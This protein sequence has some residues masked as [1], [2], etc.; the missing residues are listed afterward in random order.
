M[1][2]RPL[3]SVFAAG[4]LGALIH[5][6]LSGQI[7]PDPLDD[8]VRLSP[9]T[10]D[11]T[12]ETGYHPTNAISATRLNARVFELP[13]SLS[14]AT[15]E[16][17]RD[18]GTTD[19]QETIRFLTNVERS[20]TPLTY[21]QYNLR[22]TPLSNR[23]TFQNGRPH[24]R[25]IADNYNIARIEV[26]KGPA[27]PIVGVSPP[28]GMINYM[29]KKPQLAESFGEATAQYGSFGTRRATIDLNLPFDLAGR[30]SGMRVMA[31]HHRNGTK[32]PFEAH[33]IDG[34]T[35]TAS[36]RLTDTLLFETYVEYLKNERVHPAI[37]A[38]AT[39][40]NPGARPPY[41]S[42][43]WSINLRDINGAIIR[44]S[45]PVFISGQP[46]T[47][48]AFVQG[49]Y[50]LRQLAAAAGPDN[51]QN[52]TMFNFDATLTWQPAK[53]FGVEA[54]FS[55]SRSD[56][57]DWRKQGVNLIRYDG[58]RMVGGQPVWNPDG[59]RYFQ[60]QTFEHFHQHPLWFPYGRLSGFYDLDLGFTRQ[61]LR[62]GGEIF[63]QGKRRLT[64][65]R[66]T[67]PGTLT[68]VGFDVYLD[69]ITAANTSK[70]RWIDAGAV[71]TPFVR[72]LLP[73]ESYRAVYATA[74]GSY[75][76]NRVRTVLGYRRDWA[77]LR[78]FAIFNPPVG[79]SVLD[80]PETEIADDTYV[81]D[82][83]ILSVSVSP[84]RKLALY[85]NQS[86]SFMFTQAGQPILNYSGT[87]QDDPT[88]AIAQGRFNPD[89][90]RGPV[91]P[92]ERG[93]GHEYGLKLSLLDDRLS[94]S[95][96]VYSNE[97]V[98]VRA[99]WPAAFVQD[100]FPV[101]HPLRNQQF[102][103][104]GVVQEASGWEFEL[105]AAP[106][107]NLTFAL[108]YAEPKLVFTSHP[109]NPTI[110]GLPGVG[111]FQSLGNIVARYTVTNGNLKGVYLGFSAQYRGPFLLS[112]D[113]G[114]IYNPS[115]SV[116]NPFVGYN[117][118]G[119]E[120]W[121]YGFRVDVRNVFDTAYVT[122]NMI[123][124]SRGI[125]VSGTLRFR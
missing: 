80:D 117:G 30:Q 65:S 21:G 33:R 75:L 27:S 124:E 74:Q 56:K 35:L 58:V 82:S 71:L 68:G 61:M 14:I 59:G 48:G 69:D 18:V 92:P 93:K 42:G 106:S 83:P 22:G 53:E 115:Y 114:R 41:G 20:Q 7:A 125:F 87:V 1:R 118:R 112:N 63:D 123:G 55:T 77:R 51:E 8:V 67:T 16:F 86:R 6:S 3:S 91:P 116:V 101:D 4:A 122:Q 105:Q 72:R 96:A 47:Q 29:I 40:A 26:V 24:Q 2:N 36:S 37:L 28:V 9:F 31:V 49:I 121:T 94:A 88:T 5:S 109:A 12:Q 73:D 44:F 76:D 11:A 90:A 64:Q 17:I 45:P 78:D 52:S 97:R 54:M 39:A 25:G 32:T 98:N 46:V 34:V 62:A 119:T 19:L 104:A 113:F 107:E 10:V 120:R 79:G 23:G 89:T 102:T 13:I 81:A 111:S 57:V 43:G 15:E 60:R 50:D 110:V 95:F 100:L 103:V 38:E 84:I 108:G 66:Y 85:F 70:Q 99:T